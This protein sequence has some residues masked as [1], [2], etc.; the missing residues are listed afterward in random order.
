[1]RSYEKKGTIGT[2]KPKSKAAANKQ[3]VAI[4][5]SEAGKSRKMK[6]GGMVKPRIVKK[7]DGNQDVKIY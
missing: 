4:A 6:E 5:L 3:A 2:S 1:M 7:R